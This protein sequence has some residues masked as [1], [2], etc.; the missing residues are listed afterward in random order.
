M[1]K[2][3]R[4]QVRGVDTAKSIK[5]DGVEETGSV[6]APSYKLNIKRGEKIVGSFNGHFVDGWW[7]EDDSQEH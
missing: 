2:T 7:I 6:G 5:A 1:A 3:V 4:I